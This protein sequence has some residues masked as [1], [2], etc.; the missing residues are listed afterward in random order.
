MPLPIWVPLAAAGIQA[1]GSFLGNKMSSDAA[2]EQ[3]EQNR[4]SQEEFAKMGVR[5]RVEDAKA[6]G[7]HPLAALGAQTVSYTPSFVGDTSMGPGISSAMSQMGQG[8]ERAIAAKQT[9]EERALKAAQL[10]SINLDLE[11][12][13]LQNRLLQNQITSSQVPPALPSDTGMSPTLLSGQT[14]ARVVVKPSETSAR[15]SGAPAAQ[16]GNIPDYGFVKTPTGLSIVPSKD[17]KERIEDQFLPELMWGIRNQLAPNFDPDRFKP[18]LRD[19]PLEPGYDWD[20][21]VFK[22]EFRP[23]YMGRVRVVPM[24]K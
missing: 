7:I 15:A 6:A 12:K 17:V 14:N 22:Q 4:K 20:W 2:A 1:L 9:E 23:R 21:D 3:N 10:A 5:W 24:G 18:S 13:A 16:A 8:I 19:F 11:H